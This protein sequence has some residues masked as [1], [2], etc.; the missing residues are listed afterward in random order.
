MVLL[1]KMLGSC[2]SRL[3]GYV[4]RVVEVCRCQLLMGEICVFTWHSLCGSVGY[5]VE[6]VDEDDVGLRR[7]DLHS[8]NHSTAC[9]GLTN[10]RHDEALSVS[11]I[12]GC[13]QSL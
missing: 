9:L 3:R 7:P 4:P 12:P 5:E 2:R 6:I 8:N 13:S 10:R 1:L 11:R